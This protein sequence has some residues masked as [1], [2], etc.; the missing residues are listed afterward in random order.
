MSGKRL[1]RGA[2]LI[3]ED[4]AM[5]DQF[6][7]NGFQPQDSPGIWGWDPILLMILSFTIGPIAIAFVVLTLGALGRLLRGGDRYQSTTRLTEN[8]FKVVQQPQT[9]ARLERLKNT[10]PDLKGNAVRQFRRGQ[11]GGAPPTRAWRRRRREGPTL[12][13]Q[14]TPHGRMITPK[15]YKRAPALANSSWYK[16]ILLSRLAGPADNDGAFDLLVSRMREGTEPP[17]HVHSREDELFYVLSGDLRAYVGGEVFTLAAGECIFLPR[18]IPHALIVVSEDVCLIALITPGGY[19]D[20]FNKM[21]APAQRMEV[22][23]DPDAVTYAKA[24]LGDTINAFKRYGVR[25]LTPDE[26]LTAMPRYPR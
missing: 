9:P 12:T 25:L 1:S 22:P 5:P 23:T 11:R 3:Y 15:A 20:A 18:G 7:P 14:H 21:N 19:V 2:G 13:N 24:D 4:T 26:I 10:D 17:P 16:G 8:R 6:L